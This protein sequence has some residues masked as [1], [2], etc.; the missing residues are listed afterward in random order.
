M[1]SS[2]W[3][4][5]ASQSWR[6][7]SGIN[8][9]IFCTLQTLGDDNEVRSSHKRVCDKHDCFERSIRG[10]FRHSL[11]ERLLSDMGQFNAVEAIPQ[12][13]QSGPHTIQN[14]CGGFSREG[15]VNRAPRMLRLVS[16]GSG[17]MSV[18]EMGRSSTRRMILT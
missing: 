5:S 10:L 12:R 1:R 9:C 17:L 6:F 7:F 15:A 11:D 13:L 3:N 18:W 8:V 16:S 14:Y 4:P 2:H